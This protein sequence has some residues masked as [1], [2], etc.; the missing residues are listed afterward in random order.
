MRYLLIIPKNAFTFKGKLHYKIILLIVTTALISSCSKM[1][2]EE[3]PLGETIDLIFTVD[4]VDSD[5]TAPNLKA[6]ANSDNY[7]LLPADKKTNQGSFTKNDVIFSIQSDQRKDT[8]GFEHLLNTDLKNKRELYAATVPMKND[9]KYRLL[10]YTSS[11]AL[12]AS[13]EVTAGQQQHITVTS[14][15]TYK[16]YAYSYNT[17]TPIPAPNPSS[18]VVTTPTTTP[19][20]YASGTIIPTANGTKLPILFKHQLNQFQIEI[21]ESSGFRAILNTTGEFINADAIKTSTFNILTA[22]KSPLTSANIT[23]LNFVTEVEAGVV[24][25]VARYYTA[26]EDV[27]SFG[28]KIDSLNIQYKV[29]DPR[30]LTEDELPGNG[31]TTFAFG[32]DP[33]YKKG[34]VLKGTMLVSFTLP[35]MRIAPFSNSNASNGYRLAPATAAGKFLRTASNFG[36]GSQYVSIAQLDIDAP[37]TGNLATRTSTGWN[38]FKTLMS[39]PANYPDILIIANWY[40]YLNDECWDLVKDYIDAGG[41]VFYTHDEPDGV[42]EKYA[43]RGIGNIL[44]QTVSMSDISEY[45]GVYKFTDTPSGAGDEVILNGPFGDARS[46][47]WGQDRIGTGYINGYTGSDVIIYSTHSQNYKAPS[48]QGMCFFRHKSKSFFFVGDGGFYLNEKVIAVTTTHEDPF[49]INPTT[50]FPILQGYGYPG[51]TGSPAAGTSAGGFQIAN[52]IVFGNIISWMLNR[53]HYHG[54]NRN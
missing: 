3:G 4:G 43:Q 29:N 1:K 52:S 14:G 24:K 37:S 35:R 18:P 45:A 49:R 36:L 22:A 27:A 54:I 41:N 25:R 8:S 46:Y 39:N 20:L 40:N 38:R 5:I 21:K 44:G 2:K 12:V 19:L 31:Y 16:W 51:A 23:K 48:P 50:V 32:T 7:V 17:T 6:S 47:H 28:V 11:N 34:Y 42:Y 26:Q 53:A 9:T 30:L 15:S 33:Y 13:V 10:V